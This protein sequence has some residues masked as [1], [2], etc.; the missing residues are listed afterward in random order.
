MFDHCKNCMQFLSYLMQFKCAKIAKN[1]FSYLSR[2]YCDSFVYRCICAIW[3]IFSKNSTAD[4][5]NQINICSKFQVNRIMSVIVRHF[6][7]RFLSDC[8]IISK[9]TFIVM[10][11]YSF[12]C[13]CNYAVSVLFTHFLNKLFYWVFKNHLWIS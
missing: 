8:Y 11:L 3:V 6:S 10:F 12:V 9:L 7:N 5:R 2:N 1:E 4:F 13:C